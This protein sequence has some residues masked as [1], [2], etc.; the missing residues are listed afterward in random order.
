MKSLSKLEISPRLWMFVVC[1]LVITVRGWDRI[2]HPAL[3]AEDGN[4][5]F[6]SALNG[7]SLFTPSAGYV[8]LIPRL[9]YRILLLLPFSTIPAAACVVC[10]ALYAFVSSTIASKSYEWLIP[11]QVLRNGLS[12]VFCF[13][14]GLNEILGNA[15]N[16]Y[17]P[18]Y[19]LLALIG[20]QDL[21]RP[22][23]WIDAVLGF[24]L[25]ASAG[26]TFLLF[27]LFAWRIFLAI[28]ESIPWRKSPPTIII[29]ISMVTF[30]VINSMQLQ[31]IETSTE[32]SF[33]Q[34]L[35]SYSA[36]LL[37]QHIVAPVVGW[38][39]VSQLFELSPWIVW[40]CGIILWS[41]V[42]KMA[43]GIPRTLAIQFAL[44][45]CAIL[46]F[47]LITFIVRPG[48]IDVFSV[49]NMATPGFWGYR[50][51]MQVYTAGAIV[52]FAVLNRIKFAEKKW[53]P[54]VLVTI[55]L[56]ATL[57]QT[58]FSI[59][60]YGSLNW[61]RYAKSLQSS[62]ETGRPRRVRYPI[63]PEGWF[64]VYESPIDAPVQKNKHRPNH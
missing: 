37:G 33:L 27:P 50:Y 26:P 24:M 29:L 59:A 8:Q 2:M 25:C 36:V 22:L 11:S 28:R 42:I 53:A 9:I 19:L 17:N 45:E 12:L 5:H 32:F 47:P 3:W 61:K 20:L 63:F 46:I 58:P 14:P 31:S 44:F 35:E 1:L 38:F 57:N 34:L 13:A 60:S 51:S 7:L 21:R 30:S 54:H 6:L 52:I 18:L 56:L 55:I 62:Y 16:L 39:F 15:A 4:V 23:G 40:G 41:F 49:R 43:L 10:F 64:A 48:A